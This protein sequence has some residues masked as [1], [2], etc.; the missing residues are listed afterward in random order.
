M[1]TMTLTGSVG[2]WPAGKMRRA[3]IVVETEQGTAKILR[4]RMGIAKLMK[5]RKIWHWPHAVQP[6]RRSK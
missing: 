2:R 6:F 3:E 4:S 5:R 1:F